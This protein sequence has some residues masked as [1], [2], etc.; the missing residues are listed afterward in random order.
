MS[1]AAS[2]LP[3]GQAAIDFFP[4]FGVPIYGYKNPKHICRLEFL[5][6]YHRARAERQTFSHPR[7]RVAHEERGRYLPGWL[8]RGLYRAFF[9]STLR[10]YQ[11]A[12]QLRRQAQ[13]SD[14]LSAG[15]R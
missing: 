3:P 7:G 10:H 1:A 15:D 8:Y 2:T 6:D 14:V 5:A 11:Q 12:A 13:G 4:R 9:A